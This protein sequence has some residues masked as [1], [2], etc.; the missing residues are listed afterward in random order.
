MRQ[1]PLPSN[2]VSR[3]GGHRRGQ[4]P[5]LSRE[6]PTSR[7]DGHVARI[8]WP[9]SYGPRAVVRT[10]SVK[11]LK[12]GTRGSRRATETRMPPRSAT[13][14]QLPENPLE[15]RVLSPASQ[16]EQSLRTGRVL[17]RRI[18][19]QLTGCLDRVLI[20]ACGNRD[21]EVLG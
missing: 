19:S 20:G 8:V 9:R 14:H 18:S 4:R 7:I 2:V 3:R 12:L 15:V 10:Q 17:A 16:L 1:E 13:T 5:P 21:M 6:A 11:P